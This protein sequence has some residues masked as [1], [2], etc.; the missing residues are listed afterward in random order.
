MI[1]QIS[2]RMAIHAVEPQGRNRVNTAFVSVMYLGQLTGTKAGNEVYEKYGGWIA[3]GSL[4]V[5]VI[6]FSYLIIALRG[7]HEQGWI[8]WGGGWGLKPKGKKGDEDGEEKGGCV[9][10]ASVQMKDMQARERADQGGNDGVDNC[11]SQ[12]AKDGDEVDVEKG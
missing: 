5:A 9:A 6:A 8:G 7:P 2:N 4:S 10:K 1:V 3:S 12:T 11:P